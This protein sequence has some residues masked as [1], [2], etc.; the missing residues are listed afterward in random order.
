[1]FESLIILLCLLLIITL[2]LFLTSCLMSAAMLADICHVI[3]RGTSHQRLG[4]IF[5]KNVYARAVFVL[6]IQ[7]L[8][9]SDEN[10]IQEDLAV[11]LR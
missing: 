8:L 7:K 4:N 3:W 11:L 9:G 1:M 10:M 6:V 5:Y 2:K